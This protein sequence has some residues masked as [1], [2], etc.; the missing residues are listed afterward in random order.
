MEMALNESALLSE[1]STKHR[2]LASYGMPG[3]KTVAPSILKKPVYATLSNTTG[4]GSFSTFSDWLFFSHET[5]LRLSANTV[6]VYK[7]SG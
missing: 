5:G 2:Y 4:N 3:L 1:E 7:C 6:R